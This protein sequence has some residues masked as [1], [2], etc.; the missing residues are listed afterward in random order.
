MN[1]TTC[2]GHKSRNIFLLFT[3]FFAYNAAEKE[4]NT[5]YLVYNHLIIGRRRTRNLPLAMSF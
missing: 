1:I 4:A 2:E 5:N 3:F